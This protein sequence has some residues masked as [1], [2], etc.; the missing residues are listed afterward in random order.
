MRP[1]EKPASTTTPMPATPERRRGAFGLFDP[2]R[3]LGQR[4]R[5]RLHAEMLQVPQLFALLM[6]PRNGAAWTDDE[7]FLLRVKLRA[8]SHLSVVCA[9]LALPGSAVALPLLAWWLDRRDR[10]RDVAG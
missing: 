8:L 7:R 4:E 3:Q 5:D 2:L 10:Q 1:E 9:I 6:K